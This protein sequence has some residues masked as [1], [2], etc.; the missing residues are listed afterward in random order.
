M[1]P[2]GCRCSALWSGRCRGPVRWGSALRTDW[3]AHAAPALFNL[4]QA[5]GPRRWQHIPPTWPQGTAC[6]PCP[7]SAGRETGSLLVSPQLT[8]KDCLALQ[9]GG[10]SLDSLQ[11][12]DA[13]SEPLPVAAPLPPPP[14]WSRNPRLV[15]AG[16]GHDSRAGSSKAGSGDSRPLVAACWPGADR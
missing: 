12:K 6:R 2:R 9:G 16:S 1:Y 13:P 7:L 10:P 14:N 11:L 4:Q 5:A 15:P 8:R 3:A